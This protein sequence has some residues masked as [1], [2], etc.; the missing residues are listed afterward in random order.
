MVVD[1]VVDRGHMP[2]ALEKF[3][4]ADRA[5]PAVIRKAIKA[6]QIYI[7]I[8]GFRY[9]AIVSDQ[10][11]S[12]SHLEF[13]NA[14]DHEAIVV[15]FLLADSEVKA[16]RGELSAKLDSKRIEFGKFAAGSLEHS[17]LGRE[18]DEIEAEMRSEDKLWKFRAEVVKDRFSQMFSLSAKADDAELFD[19]HMVLKALLR[20]EEEAG[21]KRK[22][23][24]IREPVDRNLAET[25]AAVS[26][27]RFFVDVVAALT[28]F[29]KLF[30]RIRD[31]A[32]EKEASAKFFVDTY[33]P[34]LLGRE[35]S[36][37]LFFESGST[38]AYVAEAVGRQLQN[39]R[40]EITI[41]TNNVLAYLIFWLVHRIRCSLFPWGP[42]EEQYGA[43]L[44]PVN[45]LVPEEKQPTFPPVSLTAEELEAIRQ[46]KEY[47]YG[48]AKWESSA[49]LLGAISGLQ[50]TNDAKIEGCLGPHVGSPRNKIFKRFM[51]ST[52]LPLML[53]LASKKIDLR[54]DPDHC[55]FVLD[56]LH[57]Q[58]LTWDEFIQERPVAFCVGCQN[59]YEVLAQ[60]V[61]KFRALGLRVLTAQ[62]MSSH[63]AFIARKEKIIQEFEK[64]M[65]IE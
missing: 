24:W 51:Y 40:R 31:Q 25:M 6:S 8:L 59:D 49:L 53:F 23:G 2:I 12:F 16:S 1:A 65:I 14:V 41:S 36:T 21:R 38:I 10:G 20:A 56:Q 7:V 15:P 5:V 42:P 9:G 61:E 37:N 11:I 43:V 32:D 26:Q 63:T 27:S 29:Q 57:G 18:I 4:A 64:G 3:P 39:H 60:N 33:L 30:P 34:P 54:V 19:K 35:E 44:G 45:D 50:I 55:H 47:A 17:N 46:L 13:K 48:P 28:R 22:A 62:H 58:S 52:K